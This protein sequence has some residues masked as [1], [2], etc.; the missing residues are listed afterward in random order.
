LFED[1]ADAYSRASLP[2]QIASFNV[3]I[4]DGKQALL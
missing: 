4:A 3:E 2:D 1:G